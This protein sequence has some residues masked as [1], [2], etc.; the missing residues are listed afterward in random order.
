MT[1]AYRRSHQL[2]KEHV[3]AGPNDVI[4]T[5]GY[6]MTAVINKLMRILSLKGCGGSN[7]C[8]KQADRPV[9]FL[10]HMEHHSNHTS[11]FETL[12]DV[13]MI[14]PTKDLRVDLDDLRSKLEH[15]RDRKFKIGSFTAC[16]NVTGVKTPYHQLARI[17]HEHG[18]VVFIDFAASAPYMSMDM[19]PEDPM[20]KL[21]AIFFSPHKFLGGP[22]SSG[23]LIFDKAMYTAEVPDNPGGGTVDWTNPWGKYKYVDDIEVREDGGTPGFL[24][25]IKAALAIELKEQMGVDKIMAREEELLR[26]ALPGLRSIE[27]IKI[28][29]NNVDDRLGVI[30]FYH[31]DIHFNLFVKL[32]NDRFGIQTRGGCACAGTYG[33]FLLEVSHDQSE[34]IT[35]KINHGDL[36]EKP[37]WVRWSLHPTMTDEDVRL[38]LHAIKEISQNH[39]EWAREFE[40]ITRKNEFIHKSQVKDPIEDRIMQDWFRL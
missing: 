22:G 4:I 7:D 13:V 30:S 3:N 11:W 33:H 28:L 35:E 27:G 39:G 29:A 25:S 19:H 26:I 34:K 37:G 2:I 24:Q 32:L 38:I 21:D 16:S 17:M 6:G 12:A 8:V 10:T 9:V 5:A 18:G 36:S 15:Y 14:Q 40:Y 23:V 1:R 31:P 20:E